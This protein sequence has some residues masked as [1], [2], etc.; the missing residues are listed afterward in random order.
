[1][2]ADEERYEGLEYKNLNL[3]ESLKRFIEIMEIASVG[4]R[5]KYWDEFQ[6]IIDLTNEIRGMMNTKECSKEQLGLLKEIFLNARSNVLRAYDGRPIDNDKMDRYSK[7]LGRAQK[8][9]EGFPKSKEKESFMSSLNNLFNV[10]CG[11]FGFKVKTPERFFAETKREPY[12]EEG[13]ELE[14][15]SGKKPTSSR[16]K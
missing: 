16:G 15:L 10:L 3:Q 14:D 9:F 1:M 8:E 4:D 2:N 7:L 5:E 13:T 11:R 12:K 6:G